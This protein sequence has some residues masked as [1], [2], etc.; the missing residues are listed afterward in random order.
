[1]DRGQGER[2]GRVIALLCEDGPGSSWEKR[3]EDGEGG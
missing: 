2:E 1:M 3:E